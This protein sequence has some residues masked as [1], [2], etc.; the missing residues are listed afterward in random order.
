MP[1]PRRPSPA[2]LLPK[3][4][5]WTVTYAD[6]MSLLL[7]L[8]V[9]IVAFSTVE[10]E[11]FRA[12]IGSFRGALLI[13]GFPGETGATLTPA[14]PVSVSDRMLEQAAEELEAAAREAEVQAGVEVHMFAGML[15]V[16]FAD[17][18]LFDEG[19]AEIKPEGYP[20]MSRVVQTALDLKATEVRIEGHTDDTPI[21]TAQFPSNWELSTARALAVLKFFQARGYPPQSLV[22]VG[23]G[24]Y[25]PKVKLPRT[26]TRDQKAPNR[27]VEV[28][29]S[30]MPRSPNHWSA[31]TAGGQD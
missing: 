19:R 3:A 25:R 11:K 12:A 27:R 6:V 5:G 31:G 20:V 13:P 18:L 10:V 1:P 17:Y 22:A 14:P 9:M 8:F 7:V 30:F 28:F 29:L 23:Y 21:H 24:E 26:A 16:T 15:K 2:D 4:P